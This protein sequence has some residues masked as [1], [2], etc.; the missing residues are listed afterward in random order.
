MMSFGGAQGMYEKMMAAKREK[1]AAAAAAAAGSSAPAAGAGSAAA[2]RRC[3]PGRLGV[4]FVEILANFLA[5]VG[6]VG[7]AK[8]DEL[9]ILGWH[10][11]RQG[12]L[13]PIR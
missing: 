2:S 1:E 10:D 8:D 3:G 6:V 4:A 7:R 9:P 12:Q 13:E 5:H 11:R